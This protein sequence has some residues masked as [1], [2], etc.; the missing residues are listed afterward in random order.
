VP[1]A[2]PSALDS[3]DLFRAGPRTYTPRGSRQPVYGGYGSGYGSITDP[4]GYISQPDSSPRLT[5]YMR[6]GRGEGYLRID[7]EPDTARVY[8][9][10]LYEGT[11]GDFR[12]GGRALTAGPH[13]VEIR[14]DGFDPMSFDVRISANDTVSYQGSLTRREQRAELRPTTPDVLRDRAYAGDVRPRADQCARM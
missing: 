3:V 1:P 2:P 10:G 6:E 5:E 11:V 4:F 13:R 7:L 9:D 14:S 12:R 8:V